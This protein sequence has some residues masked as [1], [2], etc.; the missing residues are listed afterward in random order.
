MFKCCIKWLYISIQLTI[1]KQQ[2]ILRRKSYSIG[3]ISNWFCFSA[4]D[5]DMT[6]SR[7]YWT[8]IKVKSITRAFINGSQMERIVE[9]GLDSPEGELIM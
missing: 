7:I 4:L 6:D 1:F 8:D 3:K 9:F 2:N 5:F